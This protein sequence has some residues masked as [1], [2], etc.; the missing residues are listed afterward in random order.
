MG[1]SCYINAVLQ[2]VLACSDVCGALSRMDGTNASH[3]C[4]SVFPHLHQLSKANDTSQ[5]VHP[6]VEAVR[7][8][9]FGSSDDQQD[10]NDFLV[11][12]CN[13]LEE[14]CGKGCLDCMKT[15][16]HSKRTHRCVGREI[17]SSTTEEETG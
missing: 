9:L 3:G 15:A 17:R 1:N 16:S 11:R 12:L 10:A 8:E 14:E 4:R 6:L 2:A 13:R 5:Y 7:G